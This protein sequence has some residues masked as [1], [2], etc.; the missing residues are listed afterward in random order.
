MNG[1]RAAFDHVCGLVK[2]AHSEH[3]ALRDFVGFPDDIRG[4]E[5]APNASPASHLLGDG[6][7]A[8]TGL[9]AALRDGFEA[10][11][12]FAHWRETYKGT[13]IGADFLDR[14]G[15]YCLIGPN[16]P[17]VS[18]QMAGFVVFMPPHL[19]YTWHQ[20]PAEELY[21]VL[22]GE[23]EF[24]RDGA[25]SETL[26]AGQTSFHA[27]NQP[28]SMTT[29]NHPVMAYVTWRSHLGTPPVLSPQAQAGREFLS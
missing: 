8:A 13:D 4:Q 29:H 1:A 11:S 18:D 21:L 10:A 6:T 28:H 25:P 14:F 5:F 12:P 3:A 17:F 7:G 19:H 26:R 2:Q 23:A 20:H 16:A 27:S 9:M 24:H 22:S 15:C